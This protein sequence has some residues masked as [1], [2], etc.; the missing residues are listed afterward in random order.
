MNG[1]DMI[2]LELRTFLSGLAGGFRSEQERRNEA[3]LRELY[4]R[5]N[6]GDVP[7]MAYL[8]T[9]DYDSVDVATGEH[10]VGR[11]AYVT[12]QQNNR[13]AMPDAQTEITGLL[14]CGEVAV[15]EVVNRGTQ[16]GPLV[17]PAGELPP[18]GRSVEGRSCE[19]YTF[20][21]GLIASGRIYYDLLTVINQL[22][23][24]L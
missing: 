18:T 1:V 8:L 9:E 21:N 3:T 14:A 24:S 5:F 13:T 7:S 19:I 17:L 2:G 12:R 23:L 10:S 4:A 11:P 22:G 6:R 15:A 16:T 20:R